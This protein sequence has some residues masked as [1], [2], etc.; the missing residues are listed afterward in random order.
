MEDP[1]LPPVIIAVVQ[2]RRGV[3]QQGGE[4]R[5][6]FDHRQR[7]HVFVVKMQEIENKID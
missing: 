5:F 1:P 2:W 3:R 6:A 4:P 7:A